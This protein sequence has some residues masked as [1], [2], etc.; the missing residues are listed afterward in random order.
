MQVHVVM[1]ML[2]Y[3][4]LFIWWAVTISAGTFFLVLVSV[5]LYRDSL[6]RLETG[7]PKNAE[8]LRT[9]K[10]FAF[11]WVLLSLLVLYIV[12]ISR[13]SYF[14]FAAG[15]ILFE[16]FLIIYILTNRNK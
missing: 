5:Y 4:D 13:S 3:P 14:L 11:V 15:N 2:P 7:T 1:I 8:W 9:G 10:S 16:V 6:K 12:S